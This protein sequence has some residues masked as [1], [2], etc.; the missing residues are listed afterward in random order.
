MVAELRDGGVVGWVL[1]HMYRLVTSDCLAQVAGLVVDENHRGQGVGALL[2]EAAEKWARERGCRG[3][4]LRSR[5]MRK[6]AHAFYRRLGYTNTK[7]QEVF[8]KEL[9]H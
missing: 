4:I 7:T 2:M 1:I 9:E 5:V 6:E 3:V 8:L